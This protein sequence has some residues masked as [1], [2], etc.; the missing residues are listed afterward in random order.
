MVLRADS[1]PVPFWEKGEFRSWSAHLPQC[2]RDECCADIELEFE[3]FRIGLRLFVCLCA[4]CR[5]AMP[6]QR[7]VGSSERGNGT[8]AFGELAGAF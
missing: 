2:E 1:V 8:N 7:K 5:G 4:F 3:R 6:L